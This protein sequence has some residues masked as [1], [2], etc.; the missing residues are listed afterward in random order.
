M[1]I[2][3]EPDPVGAIINLQGANCVDSEDGKAIIIGTGGRGGYK[4]YLTPGLHINKSGIFVGLP[5]GTY[6]LRVVDTSGCEYRTNITINP[7][8]NPLANII[9][10]QDLACNGVGN[11]GTATANVAGGMPPYTYLWSTRPP[12]TTAQASTLYFGYYDVTVTDANGCEVKD[13]VYIEEGPC[14]DVAFIPNAFSPNGDQMNDEFRVLTTAGVELIQLE[15]YN[16][17]G[18]RVWSTID[19]RR[20]WD[21]TIDGKDAAIDTYYYI[22]RYKCTRDNGTYTKKGDIILIR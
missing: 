7:P 9:T 20:G 4:Y 1:I 18:K 21:G 8:A 6:L 17:W 14:C 22:L 13:T 16:R 19:Y 2:V 5:A 11:E 15:I 3:T 10:K 12:Q